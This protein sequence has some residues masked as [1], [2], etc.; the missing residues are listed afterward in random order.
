MIL[1]IED[2]RE[3]TIGRIPTWARVAHLFGIHYV[4]YGSYTKEKYCRL[5]N[6]YECIRYRL[7]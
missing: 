6:F 1:E 5:C 3:E 2:K 7:K 4:R